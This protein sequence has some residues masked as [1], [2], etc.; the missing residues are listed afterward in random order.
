MLALITVPHARCLTPQNIDHRCDAV[1]EESARQLVEALSHEFK[2][3]SFITLII[4]DIARHQPAQPQPGRFCDLNRRACRYGPKFRDRVREEI[5][6]GVRDKI[7]IWF[8]DVH[9]YPQA[10]D[11]KTV[12][13]FVL[14]YDEESKHENLKLAQ[15]MTQ[16][17]WSVITYLGKNNDLLDEAREW[18]VRHR[19]L[20]EISEQLPSGRRRQLMSDIAQWIFFAQS[21]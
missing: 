20:L 15:S 1:A 16:K 14:L 19:F 17:G 18:G 6:R 21:K 7:S 13:D 12:S 10:Y 11:G 8:L 4:G 2:K 3:G 9:S 5:A